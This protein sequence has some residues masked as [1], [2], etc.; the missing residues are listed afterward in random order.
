MNLTQNLIPG[1][2]QRPFSIFRSGVEAESM[3][4]GRRIRQCSVSAS[5][6]EGTGQS[7]AFLPRHSVNHG[8]CGAPLVNRIVL[9]NEEGRTRALRVGELEFLIT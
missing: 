8:V 3:S 4:L 7:T 2:L 9:S 6:L 5:H 1:S